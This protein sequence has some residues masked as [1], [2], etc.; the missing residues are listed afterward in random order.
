[1]RQLV[2]GSLGPKHSYRVGVIDTLTTE[3]GRE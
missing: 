3:K 2:E 1:M